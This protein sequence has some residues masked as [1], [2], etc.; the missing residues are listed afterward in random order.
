MK[1]TSWWSSVWLFILTWAVVV[2]INSL[3]YFEG[4]GFPG[5]VN[6]VL[7]HLKMTGHWFGDWGPVLLLGITLLAV[8]TLRFRLFLAFWLG[9]VLGMVTAIYYLP[10]CSGWSH[11]SAAGESFEA[12]VSSG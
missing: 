4:I 1:R 12:S 2:S 6:D 9:S 7:M 5:K 10:Q 11:A 8:V 3:I